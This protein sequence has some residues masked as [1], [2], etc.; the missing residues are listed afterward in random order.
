M[1]HALPHKKEENKKKGIIVSIMVH[2]LLLLIALIPYLASEEIPQEISGIIVAFGAPDAGSSDANPLAKTDEAVADD[3]PKEDTSQDDN[4]KSAST[5]KQT[6][7]KDP[8]PSKKP[9][10]DIKPIS[11]ISDVAFQEAQKEKAKKEAMAAEAEKKRRQAE[12]I[13]RQEA[14]K[15]AEEDAKKAAFSD[16]KSKFSDLLGSGKGNNNNDSNAGDPKGNPNS[17]ALNQIA[18]G[19]GR[20]GGGLTDRGVLFEPQIDDNSQFT[21]V[22]VVKVCVNKNGK[23]IEANYTQMGSTT[24]NKSLVDLAV[25]ASKKYKFTPSEV[26]TQCGNITIDFKVQ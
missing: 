7:T 25:S 20:I 15:K 17:D 4:E 8:A 1:D 12:E 13:A 21:G 19:S 9:V 10:S 23:V 2:V 24:T 11:N 14:Q 5:A 22:V 26:E 6:D 18:T 3:I 16:S